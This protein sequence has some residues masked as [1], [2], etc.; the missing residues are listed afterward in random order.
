M[1]EDLEAR[2][3]ALDQKIDRKVDSLDQKLERQG[4]DLEQRLTIRLGGMMAVGIALSR[5][6]AATMTVRPA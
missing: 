3:D 5:P 6:G 2:I 1:R 4:R